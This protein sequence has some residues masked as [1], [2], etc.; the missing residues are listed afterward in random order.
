M[1]DPSIES[2]RDIPAQKSIGRTRI[3]YHGSPVA[4]APPAITNSPTSVTVSN[5]S[6]NSRPTGTCARACE[7]SSSPG[8]G[9]LLRAPRLS[10]SSRKLF[11]VEGSGL[12][13]R[14]HP[15]NPGMREKRF[16]R[17]IKIRNVPEM[18]VPNKP[19]PL[20]QI[21]V[22]VG[23]AGGQVAAHP[24]PEVRREQRRWWSVRVKTRN[25]RTSVSAVRHQLPS[26]V[27]D[28]G[29]VIGVESM[30]YAER[31]RRDTESD[32]EDTA[33]DRV[34]AGDNQTEKNCPPD[35]VEC[36]DGDGHSDDAST[37]ASIQT[38]PSAG[39]SGARRGHC[40][41]HRTSPIFQSRPAATLLKSYISVQLFR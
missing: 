14:V 36:N 38:V 5:P 30:A 40:R 17:P 21:G 10:S 33:F 4:A 34:V 19:G 9:S 1:N 11:L 39:D 12:V 13:L 16:R 31:V 27:V 25:R 24:T 7:P 20:F 28:G 8:P 29:D 32:A 35:D 26:G 23:K 15:M 6:P 41:G 3:E 2:N 22:V 37:L 18:V